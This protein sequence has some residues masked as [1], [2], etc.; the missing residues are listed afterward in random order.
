[1]DVSYR[2]RAGLRWSDGQPIT[3]RDVAFTWRALI[4]P[5]AQ[6]YLD[7][8]GYRAISRIDINDGLHLTQHF[9]LVYPEY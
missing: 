5:H 9:D 3:A 6:A 4:D 1:M 8:T 2:M 7:T